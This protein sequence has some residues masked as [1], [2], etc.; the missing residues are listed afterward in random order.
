LPFSDE[1]GAG[2]LRVV[3]AAS[4]LFF[5]VANDYF[6]VVRLKAFVE[7]RRIFRGTQAES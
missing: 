1:L 6:Q 7:F 2:A 3:W 5:F 4:T